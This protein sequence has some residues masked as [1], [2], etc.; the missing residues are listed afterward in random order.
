MQ[1]YYV[2][3][4][5]LLERF[6]IEISDAQAEEILELSPELKEEI[7]YLPDTAAREYL[8][9]GLVSFVFNNVPP[10]KNETIFHKKIWYWPCYGSSNEYKNEFY[11]KFLELTKK[12]NIKVMEI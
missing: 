7:Q 5:Y 12:L 8:I 6:G 3:K 10:P 1:D 9:N 4:Q 2:V 11:N